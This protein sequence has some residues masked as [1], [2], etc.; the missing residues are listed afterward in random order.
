MLIMFKIHCDCVFTW[1]KSRSLFYVMFYN[2][3]VLMKDLD[4]PAGFC[5]FLCRNSK[6]ENDKLLYLYRHTGIAV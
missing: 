1:L 4:H 3:M 5:L 2:I 6:E